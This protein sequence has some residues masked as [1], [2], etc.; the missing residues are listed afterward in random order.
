MK[1]VAILS[2][3]HKINDVDDGFISELGL[4]RIISERER[5]LGIDSGVDF[6]GG[7]V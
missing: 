2:P 4:L 3:A 5:K 7:H 6:K 1:C